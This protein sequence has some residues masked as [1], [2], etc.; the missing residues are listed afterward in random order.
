MFLLKN[1]SVRALDGINFPIFYSPEEDNLYLKVFHRNHLAMRSS[2]PLLFVNDTINYDFSLSADMS[3]GGA[4]SQK[5]LA[6]GIWGM[7]SGD[8]NADGQIDNRDKNKIWY[9]QEGSSGYFSGDFNMDSQ[10]D[11]DDK[12]VKWQYNVGKG[13]FLD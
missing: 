12:I 5:Q 1:G 7:I 4:F 2:N 8:G 6:P 10:V 3:I 9:E 13:I 11:Q